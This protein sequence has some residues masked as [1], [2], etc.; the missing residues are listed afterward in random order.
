LIEIRAAFINPWNQSPLQKAI[1]H[2]VLHELL[3]NHIVSNFMGWSYPDWCLPFACVI[4]IAEVILAFIASSVSK[5]LTVVVV[6]LLGLQVASAVLILWA[7][8]AL[9]PLKTDI[10]GFFPPLGFLEP[11]IVFGLFWITVLALAVIVPLTACLFFFRKR[12]GKQVTNQ[13]IHWTPQ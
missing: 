5:R 7:N 4:A 12:K 3:S 6:G 2:G 13:H 8:A 1:V 9:P 10:G 11:M